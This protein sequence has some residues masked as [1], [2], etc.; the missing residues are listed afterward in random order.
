MGDFSNRL[1]R[2]PLP[3]DTEAAADIAQTFAD[4]APELRDLLGGTAGCSPFLKGLIERDAD[5]LREALSQGP[6]AAMADLMAALMPQG[7]AETGSALRLGKRRIALL[8]ALADLGGLWSL[9]EVTGALTSFADA[10]V[11]RA[12][13]THL[14]EEIRRKK[15]PGAQP[16]DEEHGA[17]MVAFAMGKMG[18]GE[19]NYSSDIDLICLFDE[20]RFDP[21]D[22]HEARQAFI[23]ATRKASAMLNDPTGEGY[24]FRTDLRLR[25]DASVT[26]VCISMDAAERYYES[27]GRT[28]ERAAWIKARPCAGDLEAGAKFQE[29]LRPFVWRRHLDFWAIEDAYD[30]IRRIREHKGLS[31]PLA[32]ESHNLKL[33]R[34]G[35]REIEF[36]TQTRQLIAGGR[37]PALRHRDTVGALAALS[38]KGWVPEAVTT[39]LTDAYRAHREL[40][41]RLQMVHDAQTQ[42]LPRTPEEWDRIARFSGQGDT[43]A[44]RKDLRAQLEA[45]TE[46]TEDFFQP[47]ETGAEAQAPT[48]RPVLSDQ[49]RGIVQGWRAYPALRSNRAQD[50]FARLE[51]EILNRLLKAPVPDDA[52]V[53]FDRFLAGLPAGVQLFSLFEANPTL[54]DLLGD[55]L[56]TAPA[57]GQYLS[58]NAEVFEAVIAGRFFSDWPG[59]DEL[60]QGLITRLDSEPDYEARLDAARAWMKDW[61]FRIGVHHLRGLI[62]SFEAAKQYADLADAVLAA[63]WP[64]VGA[65]FARKHGPTPGRGAVV[66]GMGSL[67]SGRL[68]ATSDLDLIVIYDADGEESSE[69]PRPLGARAYFARLTQAMV[70]ALS[71]P[72]A[73]GRLY[74]VDM[75]LRPSGRQ[76]P[77]ATALSAFKSYQSGEA[78]TWEH[79][80]LTRARRVAGSVALGDEVEAFRRDLLAEKAKSETLRADVA[81]MRARLRSAKPSEGALDAKNGPGRLQDIELLAQTLALQSAAPA[82]RIEAQLA[83]GKRAGLIG[84][85]EED[86][87]GSAYR[88]L[89]HLH[90]ATRLLA[91][92]VL[93]PDALGEGA[94][95]LVLRETASEDLDA[96]LTRL[97]SATAESARL[98]D[99]LLDD[100]AEPAADPGAD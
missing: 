75:R 98:I 49:Q 76:G 21:D 71:A 83:A 10:A 72:M 73:Q 56:S 7:P 15:I 61:H 31:G 34:G 28:W 80:A 23:R 32:L 63:I 3:F 24:V 27:L 90:G 1:T 44:F 47:G 48:P 51:P 17:G 11:H 9:E 54:I 65:E 58:R 50:I 8:A 14:A 41:H 99:R 55:I 45:V 88:L 79:L 52:I 82:R 53:N 13:A 12:F 38:D 87:L 70:T 4:L 64:V 84:G 36:F 25:P 97:E 93:D 46:L 5:W 68:N 29:V 78:W 42:I 81:A 20:S 60:T 94:R 69:G 92:R 59:R 35:I 57:L 2:A 33:G 62:D 85:A 22:W 16:G 19:L 96:L 37:D 89:W 43:E 91:D 6:E 67:G 66:L 39:Q 18:A 86:A 30:M 100:A 74:E 40:E 77:V 26:P 95:A